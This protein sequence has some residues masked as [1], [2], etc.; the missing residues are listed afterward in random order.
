MKKICI[1]MIA[2][3]GLFMVQF[4]CVRA[5]DQS[6]NLDGKYSNLNTEKVTSTADM[7]NGCKNLQKINFNDLDTKNINNIITI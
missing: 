2:F 1:I 5:F 3:F 6:V 7:F 4:S